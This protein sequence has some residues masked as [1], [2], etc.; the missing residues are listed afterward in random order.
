MKPTKDIT[1]NQLRAVQR[2]LYMTCFL[3][4]R[5]EDSKYENLHCQMF[6]M[7]CLGKGFLSCRIDR[8]CVFLRSFTFWGVCLLGEEGVFLDALIAEVT[9]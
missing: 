5:N 7:A 1:F 6:V 2:C 9:G 3:W 4:G 8:S